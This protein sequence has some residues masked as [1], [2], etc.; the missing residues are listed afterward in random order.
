MA[1]MGRYCKAYPV[2]RLR[3]FPG[4]KENAQGLK[5]EKPQ[6]GMKKKKKPQNGAP[7]E[8]PPVETQRV[9]TDDD[10][11][12]LQENF[13]VTDGIFIDENIVFDDVTPEWLEFCKETLKFEIP[14]YET[15]RTGASAQ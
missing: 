2:V 8:Q 3:E 7:E 6:A 15:A 5:K 12:Y 11:L 4:W 10:Y 14:V 9:L 13:V 1:E